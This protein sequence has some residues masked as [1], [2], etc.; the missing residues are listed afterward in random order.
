[1]NT[2]KA[3]MNR[4]YHAYDSYIH[5]NQKGTG[6][7]CHFE[8]HPAHGDVAG[9]V[10]LQIAMQSTIGGYQGGVQVFPTFDWAHKI[11]VKLDR[12]DLSQI[13]QVLRGMKEDIADGKGLFHRTSRASTVIKFT[14][15]IDPRPGYLLSISRKTA[16]GDVQNVC[17]L[18]NVDEAFTLMLSLERAMMYVCL[19]IP[20]VIERPR[21]QVPMMP[22]RVVQSSVAPVQIPVE[23]ESEEMLKAS[24]D[25]F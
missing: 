21:R 10:F 3:E 19:G 17:F 23:T 9:S 12:V 18:F 5:A 25:P 8:L 20:E 4:R 15:Q 2:S 7:A 1:M 22:P 16:E 13:L 24:G 14:H 6:S 11:V